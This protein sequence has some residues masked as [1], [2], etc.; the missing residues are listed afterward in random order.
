MC[1]KTIAVII[2]VILAFS[3]LVLPISAETDADDLLS[4][5]NI[6][7]YANSRWGSAVTSKLYVDSN[8]LTR[9]E[10]Q[11]NK[12]YAESFDSSFNLISSKTVDGELDDVNG[13]YIGQKYNFIVCSQKNTNEDDT[14][15]VVRIIKYSKDWSRLSS[16]SIYGANT[17]KFTD[18]GSLRFLE[19]GNM[20]YIHTS[21]EM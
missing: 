15:E 17:T 7:Y 14:K 8:G 19:Y 11:N 6:K 18:A 12:V 5:S 1:K 20:L 2:S 4:S 3:G 9:I 10:F 16:A 13:V 21:H